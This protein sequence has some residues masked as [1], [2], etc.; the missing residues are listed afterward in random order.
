MTCFFA[1]ALLQVASSTSDPTLSTILE[2]AVVATGANARTAYRCEGTCLS[3]GAKEK[4][5]F[6]FDGT[7]FLNSATGTLIDNA[8]F[9]GKSCWIENWSG[10][11]HYVGL[12]DKDSNELLAWVTT[13]QWALGD[14]PLTRRLTDLS[15][16]QI[17]LEIKPKDG[18]T[19]ATL[20]L[21]EDTMLPKKLKYWTES[22]DETWS[23]SDYQKFGGRTLPRHT[24]HQMSQTT[25]W[26][27]IDKAEQ[28]KVNPAEF[29]LPKPD[30]SDTSYSDATGNEIEI[31]RI[32]GYLF[33]RPLVNGKDVGWFFLDSG[34]D[35]MC[36]DPKFAQNDQFEDLGTDTTAGVVAVVKLKIFRGKSFQLGPVT[37]KNP[38]FY[39]FD[40]TPFQAFGIQVSGICGYDFLARSV[41]QVDPK[42]LKIKIFNPAIA[43]KFDN[44]RWE[45]LTFNGNTPSITCSFEG[46]HSGV[47]SLD[48]GSSS[49]VDLFSPIVAKLGLLQGRET[50]SVNTGGAGGSAES[51]TGTISYFEVG[52]H[53]FDKPTVGL[54]VTKQGVFASPYLAGNV[55]MGFL[56]HF[57]LIFDYGHS[58]MGFA[59]PEK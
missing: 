15:G 10:V 37:I 33:V 48:T 12:V 27:D 19:P 14:C 7:S 52:G 8:G 31:R 40:M 41:L 54:Q 26:Y 23:F 2:K 46:D 6:D 43:P 44:V 28:A 34:A 24:T 4:F 29:A 42:A 11:P 56:G 1:L 3:H 30:F 32:F 22:G 47:F 50:A 16:G 49:T 13:G 5:R 35:V 59:E 21:D 20:T 39:G 51:K 18:E 53:R 17:S 55:G 58:R 38:T 9:D 45:H 25:D 36:I 57:R